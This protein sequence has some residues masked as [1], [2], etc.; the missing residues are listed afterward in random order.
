MGA[1]GV[2][3][4]LHNDFEKLIKFWG[5]IIK[6]ATEKRLVSFYTDLGKGKKNNRVLLNKCCSISF[7]AIPEITFDLVLTT[8]SYASALIQATEGKN[9]VDTEASG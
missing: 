7:P 3:M 5:S 2:R 8:C 6:T 4:A 9:S 1:D